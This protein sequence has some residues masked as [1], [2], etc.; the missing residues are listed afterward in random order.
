MDT[1]RN[2]RTTFQIDLTT[3]SGDELQALSE[4]VDRELETR[5]FEQNLKRELNSH[6]RRTQWRQPATPGGRGRRA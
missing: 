6:L 3:L 4:Q 1:S 5:S 2:N